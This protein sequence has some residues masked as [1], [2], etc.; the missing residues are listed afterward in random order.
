MARTWSGA[1]GILS[2]NGAQTGL[3]RRS[4][5]GGV[6]VWT[7]GGAPW[8]DVAPCLCAQPVGEDVNICLSART[9]QWIENGGGHQAAADRGVRESRNESRVDCGLDGRRPQVRLLSLSVCSKS[10]PWHC[11]HPL[12]ILVCHV[13]V[14]GRGRSSTDVPP[15]DTDIIRKALV[16]GGFLNVARR[17]PAPKEF[18]MPEYQTLIGNHKVGGAMLRVLPLGSSSRHSHC[19]ESSGWERDP[20]NRHEADVLTKSACFVRVLAAPFSRTGPY[21]RNG[22]ALSRWRCI[23][24]PCYFSART[25]R[26]WCSVSWS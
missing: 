25:C 23:P 5:G 14:H 20:S 26:R 21:N 6:G 12:L 7:V 15:V 4:A 1:N 9:C 18:A 24:A 10:P 16:A 11:S 22:V 19:V 2:I 8:L 17:V 3:R 13:R